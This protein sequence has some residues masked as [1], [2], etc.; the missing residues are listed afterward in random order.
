MKQIDEDDS[1]A[2]PVIKHFERLKTLP[3]IEKDY[4]VDS[5]ACRVP[6]F[7]KANSSIRS[8]RGFQKVSGRNSLILSYILPL[9]MISSRVSIGLRN[10]NGIFDW[11]ASNSNTFKWRTSN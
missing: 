8:S 3:P 5:T 6:E 1:F 10:S 2:C 4:T 11:R 9:S 7:Q